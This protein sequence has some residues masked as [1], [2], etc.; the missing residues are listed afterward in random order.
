MRHLKPMVFGTALS[1]LALLALLGGPAV[2]AA[3]QRSQSN[4]INM[5]VTFYGFDDN[6]PPSADIAYPKDQGYP[7]VH[8][9][10]T[11]G[12]G[13][14]NDPVTFATDKNEIPIGSII[15]VPFL[16]KYFVMEDDCTECDHNWSR[17]HKYHVDLWMGPQFHSPPNAL[18]ACENKLTRSATAI[19]LNPPTNLTVDTTLMFINGKCTAHTH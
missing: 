2:S 1:L 12:S 15:Y 11:E 6:S 14:Y 9:L 7:T 19:V 13:A 17:H 18:Y 10:A 4:S 5:Y 16:E 8:N 3:V